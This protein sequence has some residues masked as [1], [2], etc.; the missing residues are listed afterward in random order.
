MLVVTCN[1]FLK[2]VLKNESLGYLCKAFDAT[3]M[4]TLAYLRIENAQTEITFFSM[5]NNL[6]TKLRS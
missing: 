4:N 2:Y 6:L 1:W 5:T 3:A